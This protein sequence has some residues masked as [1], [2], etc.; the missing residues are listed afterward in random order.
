VKETEVRI[1]NR[2]GLHA[3]PSAALTQLASRY[4]AEVWLS[5]GTRRVN[6]KSIMGVMMLAAGRGS[7]LRIECDGPDEDAALAAVA[8]LIGSGFGEV[9]APGGD[10]GAR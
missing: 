8:G 6:A 5:K 9:D 1:V 7:T 10:A 3:R 4:R 2:L